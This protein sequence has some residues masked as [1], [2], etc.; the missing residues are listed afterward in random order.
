MS[1]VLQ[2]SGV[3]LGRKRVDR[4]PGDAAIR[5]LRDQIVV[6]PL[7]WQPSK[8]LEVVYRGRTL[9]GEILAVGP[10]HYPKKYNKDRSKSWDSKHFVPT[11]VKVG[12]VVE[13]GGLEL[14]GYAFDELL[15][16]DLPVVVCREA[17]V[18]GVV[19]GP[20]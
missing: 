3:S 19:S 14:R 9:R 16:G 11:Q 1:A 6:K 17:D 12:D 7:A 15:W 4:I 8:I 20:P 18:T 5:P 2:Q 13:L 10:G